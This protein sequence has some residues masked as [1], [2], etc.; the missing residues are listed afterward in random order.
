MRK[1]VIA[2]LPA[3]NAKKS[4]LPF[5][6]T[7]PRDVFD[8][9]ILVDDCSIDGTYEYAKKQKGI[10][11]YHTR[12]NLGYGGNLKT[13]LSIAL[14]HGADVIVEIHPDGEYGTNGILPGLEEVRRG[15]KMVLGD[16]FAN[17]RRKSGMYWWKHPFTRVLTH[18]DNLVFST[19]IGDMHQGF[20]VY[21]RELLEEVNFRVNSNNYA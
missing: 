21:T 4:L 12:R 15:A 18:L 17:P 11:V 9:I 2:I 19:Q 20:R 1:K 14:E 3:Y 10:R 7:L 13:C 6:K 8:E 16:R 5:L